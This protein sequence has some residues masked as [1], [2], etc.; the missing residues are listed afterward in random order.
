[1]QSYWRMVGPVALAGLSRVHRE[2]AMSDEPQ[3]PPADAGLQRP[4]EVAELLDEL[5]RL[6]RRTR[7]IR[8]GYWFPLVLFGLLTCAATPFYILRSVPVAKAGPTMTG[9]RLPDPFL[10]VLSGVAGY[11][12]QGYL[13]Y[14]WLAAI[15]AG[16]A[17]TAFWYR[18][19][20]GRVGLMTPARGFLITGAALTVAALVLPLLSQVTVLRFLDRLWPGDLIVR[21]TFPFLIIAAGLCVLAWAERSRALT[22]ITL[23]YTGT[24]VLVSLYDIN[25]IGWNLA[26]IDQALPNVLL[27]ALVLLAAGSGAYVAQRRQ[28]TA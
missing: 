13:A 3:V 11:R 28:G 21:G 10:P 2:L 17:L 7:S 9:G 24:A 27:P 1:M 23:V 12:L 19:N 8:H 4:G 26:G 25:N 16:L 20:A 18:R 14:Y 15:V 22:A 6:R 5:G